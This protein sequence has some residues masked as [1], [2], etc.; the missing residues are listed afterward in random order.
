MIS[1][2]IS[3]LL[4]A[5]DPALEQPRIAV[6]GA[7]A[8]SDAR[9]G[10][11]GRAVTALVTEELGRGAIAEVE[12]WGRLGFPTKVPTLGE[13]ERQL[14]GARE[15][16]YRNQAQRA[17]QAIRQLLS[18][19]R[20]LPL[21]K[22]RWKSFVVAR[23]IE[24]QGLM[25][26]ARVKEANEA[27]ASI[28]R[29]EPMHVLDEE[30]YSPTIRKAFEDA[31]KRQAQSAKATLK[32]TSVPVGA[33]VYVEGFLVGATPLSVALPVRTY[34]VALEQ[35]GARS[36]PRKVSLEGVGTS[37]HAELDFEAQLRGQ[38][39]PCVAEQSHSVGPDSGI[40]K[41]AR[42][43]GVKEVALL[44]PSTEG[45]GARVVDLN[46][47]VLREGGAKVMALEP[48]TGLRSLAAFVA[49]GDTRGVVLG[50]VTVKGPARE[51]ARE[52][53]PVPAALK[54]AGLPPPEPSAG[55]RSKAWI[56]AVAGGA[57]LAGG[58]VTFA[59][60]R[61]ADTRVTIGIDAV[62]DLDSFNREL[63]R[64][65]AF[66]TATVAL[67]ASGCASLATAG[68]F[69]WLGRPSTPAA[70]SISV[71]GAAMPGGA[72]LAVSGALR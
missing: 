57:L 23:M 5:A 63:A 31:R 4:A 55:L 66:S 52:S 64:R 24:A 22:E 36:L 14:E 9:F 1:S 34:E 33:D 43:L 65:R 47:D 62:S 10:E 17:V 35:L 32:V 59:L 25:N 61:D 8:C 48:K 71:S 2:L 21:S 54:A 72:F 7:A 39:F 15:L 53:S 58:A 29:V 6:I 18:A 28:L 13:V 20:Q 37:V 16:L 19:I 42:A 26:L 69:W 50:P 30:L 27:F 60:M 70:Q 67:M 56:P 44:F 11:Q 46:G 51:Q 45:L 12:F 40:S 49:T 3:V 68:A 38:G 41:L